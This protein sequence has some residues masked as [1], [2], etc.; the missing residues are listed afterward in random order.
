MTEKLWNISDKIR[1]STL[2]RTVEISQNKYATLENE[3]GS[4]KSHSNKLFD[5]AGKP[6]MCSICHPAK[7]KYRRLSSDD[8]L[9]KDKNSK[10][11]TQMFN[12]YMNH[13]YETAYTRLLLNESVT[14]KECCDLLA[15]KTSGNKGFELT[16][17]EHSQKMYS[18]RL[19]EDHE[20]LMD[21]HKN[22]LFLKPEKFMF[23]YK[24]DMDKYHYIKKRQKYFIHPNALA[25]VNP[26]K[27]K[28]DPKYIQI[29]DLFLTDPGYDLHAESPTSS[30]E[31]QAKKTY[32]D[33][34]HNPIFCGTIYVKTDI[35]IS[36]KK[37]FFFP[38]KSKFAVSKWC[39]QYLL[40]RNRTL[41]IINSFKEMMKLY[42]RSDEDF[43]SIIASKPN[44]RTLLAATNIQLFV[45][46]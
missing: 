20:I 2:L 13:G 18:E 8:I 40:L 7:M 29:K 24:N 32:L 12:F 28:C 35:T 27:L 26:S 37:K 17:Y 34:Y 31:D 33:E 42:Y 36:F 3:D 10:E 14:A 46:V 9:D 41:Y 11:A 44:Y 1:F 4:E 30:S 25:G 15:V 5:L 23:I 22:Q 43:E 16:I 38:N 6:R 21:V 39:E 45:C 19:V